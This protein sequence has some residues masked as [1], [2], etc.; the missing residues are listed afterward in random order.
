MSSKTRKDFKDFDLECK[1]A[2]SNS[3]QKKHLL[4]T[5]RSNQKSNSKSRALKN[6]YESLNSSQ[7]ES[8]SSENSN[9]STASKLSSEY[10]DFRYKS[11][12]LTSSTKKPKSFEN[13]NQSSK[14]QVVHDK[15]K[16]SKDKNKEK[17]LLSAFDENTA[18]I[19]DL[20]T[21]NSAKKSPDM[22]DLF[23]KFDP[24]NVGL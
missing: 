20:F 12:K 19:S 6:S 24:K 10:T 22:D 13:K 8:N 16:A 23:K 9:C 7:T 14:K 5:N 15:E 3:S 4:N 17:L 2:V 18:R 21:N 11:S 1:N